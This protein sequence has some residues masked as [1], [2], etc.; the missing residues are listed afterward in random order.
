M[1]VPD[2]MEVQFI[3]YQIITQI[4]MQLMQFYKVKEDFQSGMQDF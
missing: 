4:N 2:L 3:I 1:I